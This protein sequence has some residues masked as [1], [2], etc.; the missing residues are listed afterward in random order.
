MCFTFNCS[1]QLEYSMLVRMFRALSSAGT[2]SCFDEFN[3]MDIQ[4]LSVIAMVVSDI[5][6]AIKT[7]AKKLRVDGFEIDMRNDCAMF[8]TLNPIFGGRNQ[9]TQNIKNLFRPI[10]MMIPDSTFIAENLL[11][12]RGFVNGTKLAQKI[13]K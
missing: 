8:I 5:L 9:L 13:I 6:R 11:Y 10:A 12:F 3:R 7:H 1:S 4:L 2:W